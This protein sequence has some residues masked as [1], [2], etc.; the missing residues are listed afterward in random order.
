[1]ATKAPSHVFCPQQSKVEFTNDKRVP[2]DTFVRMY[3]YANQF[4]RFG[5]QAQAR[6][7]RAVLKHLDQYDVAEVHQVELANLAPGEWKLCQSVCDSCGHSD[8][9]RGQGVGGARVGPRARRRAAARAGPARIVH[10]CQGRGAMNV[11]F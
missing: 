9:G 11:G 6:E 1:V 2:P 3:E 4:A 8:G 7:S 5:T 10:A